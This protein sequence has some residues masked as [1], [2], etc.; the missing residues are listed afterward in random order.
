M[1]RQADFRLRGC[2]IARFNACGIPLEMNQRR[3]RATDSA[4]GSGHSVRPVVHTRRV[5]G[6]DLVQCSGLAHAD[7]QLRADA[8]QNKIAAQQD[9]RHAAAGSCPAT[10]LIKNDTAHG[11]RWKREPRERSGHGAQ[12]PVRPPIAEREARQHGV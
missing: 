11:Q 12:R 5:R 3:V 6:V 1:A 4:C 2:I 8:A 9:R 10:S 7:T